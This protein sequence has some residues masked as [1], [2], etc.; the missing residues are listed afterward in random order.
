MPETKYVNEILIYDLKTLSKYKNPQDKFIYKINELNEIETIYI[1]HL[2]LNEAFRYIGYYSSQGIISSIQ[3]YNKF[4][5]S[6]H[7]NMKNDYEKIESILV[8]DNNNLIY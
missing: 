8:G 2:F 5:R 6:G 1:N 7:G 3:T 4:K